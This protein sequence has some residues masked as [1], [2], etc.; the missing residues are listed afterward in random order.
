MHPPEDVVQLA[1]KF[2]NNSYRYL[3]RHPDNVADLLRWREPKI[4][5]RMDFEKLT[6]LPDTFVTA[7]F[8][9]LESDVILCVP[10]RWKTGTDGTIEV[11]IL[12]EH[13]SEPDERMIFRVIRY[14]MLIYERQAAEWLKTHA[15]LREFEFDPVMPIVFYSGTRTW[16]QL[17]PMRELVRGGKLFEK[18][19]SHL[20]PEFIN[21]ATTT[22]EELQRKIGWLGWILWLNQ[23]RKRKMA[24]F[25]SVLAQVLQRLD[26]LVD[27]SNARW[28]HLLW[29]AQALVYHVREGDER[30]QMVEFIREKVRKSKQAEVEA[31][32]KSIAE[33]IKEEGILE[34]REE[35]V[36]EA[37]RETL[38][39]LLRLKFKRVPAAIEAEI[40]AT[41][42]VRKLDDW[43]DELVTAKT[44]SDIHFSSRP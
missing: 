4:A 22:P 44:L 23:Q 13:Q 32:G 36:L 29:Y 30:R 5:R 16:T 28:E 43:L 39:R 14:V 37:K 24:V 10:F 1:Q 35:G 11:F 38:I 15:N 19:L 3:F 42:D 31:M 20:E 33:L 41:Q 18:R 8:A 7:D 27:R 26:G 25:R 40:N 21:L 2:Q 34:G 17:T 6:V 12:I 9:A